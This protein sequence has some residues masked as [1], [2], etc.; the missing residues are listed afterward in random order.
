MARRSKKIMFNGIDKREVGSYS[1]PDFVAHYLSEEMMRMNPS[2][3]TVLDPAVGKG[4]LVG[5][6]LDAGKIVDGYDIVDYTSCHERVRFHHEDFLRR[7]ISDKDRLIKADYDYIIMNP[8]YNC[9]EHSYLVQNK[10]VL[11][12]HF[13]IGTY[14]MYALFLDAVIDIA[15]DGCIIGAIVPDSLLFTASYESLRAKMLLSCDILQIVLLPSNLFWYDYANV[16]TCMMLIRKGN[17]KRT[18]RIQIANRSADIKALRS[19][20]KSHKFDYVAIEDIYLRTAD[21]PG[22]FVFG[23]PTQLNKLFAS[24]PKLGA[25]FECGGGISTGNNELYTSQR[26]RSGFTIPFYKNVC[27]RF[28]TSVD[29]FLCDDYYVQSRGIRNFIVRN[30]SRRDSEGIVC[31]GIGSH[32]YAA[33]LPAC[34]VN[35]VNAAIWPDK[36]N[37]HWL[38]AY[39]NSSLV[40]FLMK[41][42]IA[43]SNMTTIGNVSSLPIIRFSESEKK[44]LGRIAKM[45]LAGR[46][47]SEAAV[48]K[49]DRIVFRSI[50]ATSDTRRTVTRFC[51]NLTHLL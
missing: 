44:S 42:I 9:H 8:P 33:Y 17:K 21:R 35:G 19:I 40:T 10:E 5:A 7:Y 24:C 31:S 28:S 47:E 6:F 32:F 49:I 30:H 18:G 16:N 48:I 43:R 13:N 12:E 45:A 37:L 27:S 38:L 25:M 29:R 14:N 11:K 41:G 34:G 50:D 51:A 20:L 46:L 23:C 1:T 22:I 39:L 4:E 3:H 15:K 26:M 36:D 2:G